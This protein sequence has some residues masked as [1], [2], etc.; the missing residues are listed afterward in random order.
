MGEEVIHTGKVLIGDIFEQNG[1]TYKIETGYG[2]EGYTIEEKF[3]MKANGKNF[4]VFGLRK[5]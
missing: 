3:W 2:G 5:I 1:T 4:K